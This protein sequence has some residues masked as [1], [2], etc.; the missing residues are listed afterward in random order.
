[1]KEHL[2][3]APNDDTLVLLAAQDRHGDRLAIVLSV[4]VGGEKVHPGLLLGSA[5]GPAQQVLVN[6]LDENLHRRGRACEPADV[7]EELVG[8][9][10]GEGEARHVISKER[11]SDNDR[12]RTP[13]TESLN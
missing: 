3:I 1:M 9:Y 2:V 7:I 10:A 8:G 5:W 6:V 12:S 11:H 13:P 4:A